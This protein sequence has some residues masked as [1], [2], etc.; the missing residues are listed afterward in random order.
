[1]GAS[2]SKERESTRSLAVV[3]LRTESGLADAGIFGSGSAGGWAAKVAG[4]LD[5]ATTNAIAAGDVEALLAA[6][7]LA[8]AG[9]GEPAWS[10]S[11]DELWRDFRLS[12]TGED[13]LLATHRNEGSRDGDDLSVG[14]VRTGGVWRI[15]GSVFRGWVTWADIVAKPPPDK[16]HRGNLRLWAEIFADFAAGARAEAEKPSTTAFADAQRD[17]RAAELVAAALHGISRRLRQLPWEFSLSGSYLLGE[18]WGYWNTERKKGEWKHSA[19]LEKRLE[20]EKPVR[21]QRMPNDRFVDPR[22]SR[23]AAEA[24]ARERWKREN[25]SDVDA[26]F[27]NE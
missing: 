21:P 26:V 14:L 13:S 18:Y 22:E 1:M 11:D 25:R 24:R 5:A 27:G 17:E 15:S 9:A 3:V 2:N 19:Y 16:Q 4:A 8:R 12:W 20:A 7:P 23:E 6:P 10:G